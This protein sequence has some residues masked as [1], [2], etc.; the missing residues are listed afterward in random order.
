MRKNLKENEETYHLQIRKHILEEI[1]RNKGFSIPSENQLCEYYGVCRPTVRKALEY[2]VE[3]EIIVRKQGKGSFIKSNFREKLITEEKS[4]GIILPEGWHLRGCL[5]IMQGVFP[6]SKE[7]K[8]DLKIINF[9]SL[10]F[11]TKLKNLN[12]SFTLWVSP[13]KEEVETMEELE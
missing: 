12:T 8:F 7:E 10:N 13:E 6:A 3:Q 4:I 5:K 1:N 9:S 11:S 2:L